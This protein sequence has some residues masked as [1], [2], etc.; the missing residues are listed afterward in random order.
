LRRRNAAIVAVLFGG[1]LQE[2]GEDEFYQHEHAAHDRLNLD[3]QLAV[4]AKLL[5]FGFEF[6]NLVTHQ[7]FIQTCHDPYHPFFLTKC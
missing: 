4:A 1:A 3:R 2:N 6:F 7:S 5:E